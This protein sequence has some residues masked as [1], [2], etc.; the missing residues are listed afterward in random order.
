MNYRHHR[1]NENLS[2]DKNR[3]PATSVS[4]R[5]QHSFHQFKE[6]SRVPSGGRNSGCKN[7]RQNESYP[8]KTTRGGKH[9]GSF[10]PKANNDAQKRLAISKKTFF[11]F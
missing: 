11:Y 7:H 3:Q 5:S 4:G 6:N 9:V 1:Q 10:V 8:R 2:F